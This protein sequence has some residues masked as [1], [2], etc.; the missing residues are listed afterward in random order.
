MYWC[1]YITGVGVAET[2]WVG[3]NDTKAGAVDAAL[4]EHRAAYGDGAAEV[5]LCLRSDT[6][7][8]VLTR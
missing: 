5:R 7:L 8:Q 1:V 2:L 3:V 4:A 6:P